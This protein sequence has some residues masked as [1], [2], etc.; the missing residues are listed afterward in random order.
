MPKRKRRLVLV[1]SAIVLMG[2]S[3][4]SVSSLDAKAPLSLESESKGSHYRDGKFHNESKR[5]VQLEWGTLFQYVKESFKH[6]NVETEP[7]G[8]IP[9][10]KMMTEDI[11]SASEDSVWRIGHSTLLLKI[12]G[13][14]ILLDPVFSERASPFQFIGPKRFH[15]PPI[16]IDALPLIDA[17]VISHNHYD[18][19]DKDS[20]KQ[21][22]GKVA[23]F[24][25]PL[26]NGN[27]LVAWGVDEQKITEMDWWQ[28]FHLDEVTLVSTPSQH[29]SGRGITDRD[30]TLWSSY[31][32]KSSESR[33]FFSGDTGYFNGFKEIGEK[34]GPFDLTLIETGA[35]HPSWASIHMLPEQSL[36]AHVDLKG[37]RM[38]PIHN[39]TFNLALH[40]W[41]DPFEQITRL[42][43]SQ[44]VD[45]LTPEMGEPL[46][47]KGKEKTLKWWVEI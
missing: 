44:Q 37:Q 10:R 4:M 34:Y 21:L 29:F 33:V 5:T 45:L 31:V 46:T 8:S 43:E 23:H 18:H 17:V 38:M 39:G 12:S 42:A 27:D 7:K 2:V 30:K 11:L 41:K 26:G 25:V 40:S 22:A 32:I 20:I 6:R 14:L 1:T 16:G 36:Q 47:L 28:E 35:Y 24:V 15:Q 13:K 19:L 9:V 3:A